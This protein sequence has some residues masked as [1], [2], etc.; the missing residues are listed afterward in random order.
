MKRRAFF[1]ALIGIALLWPAVR[2]TVAATITVTTLDDSGPGSLRD[3][4]AASNSGDT[5]NFAV[6]GTITLTSGELTVDKNLTI[7][8]PGSGSLTVERSTASGIPRFRIFTMPDTGTHF[9]VSI[10]GLTITKGFD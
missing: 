8:G 5:I 6:T 7:T 2:S 4:I 3:A 1:C 9:T 10:S